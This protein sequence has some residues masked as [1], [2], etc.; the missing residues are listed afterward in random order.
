MFKTENVEDRELWLFALNVVISCLYTPQS[1]IIE[2]KLFTNS[3]ES[4]EWR[5]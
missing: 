2:G 5:R 4:L 1:I 3:E